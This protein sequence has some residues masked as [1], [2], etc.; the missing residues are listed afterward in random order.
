MSSVTNFLTFAG[1]EVAGTV[2][3]YL[4]HRLYVLKEPIPGLI[5]AAL[6]GTFVA[7]GLFFLWA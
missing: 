6:G 3:A 7:I 4:G 1:L 2:L 5:V